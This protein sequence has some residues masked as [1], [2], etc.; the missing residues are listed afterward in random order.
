MYDYRPRV[1]DAGAK[2]V[3]VAP[4]AEKMISLLSSVK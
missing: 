1:A 2:R 4:A 3:S